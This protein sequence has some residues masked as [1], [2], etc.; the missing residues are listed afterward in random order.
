MFRVVASCVRGAA[1]IL[2]TG[3]TRLAVIF[4]GSRCSLSTAGGYDFRV[5][6]GRKHSFKS[7]ISATDNVPDNGRY[8]EAYHRID[9]ILAYEMGP[10][11]GVATTALTASWGQ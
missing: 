2:A 3:A 11:R 10:Q 5:L 1:E 4:T 9:E 6:L 8:M 7:S